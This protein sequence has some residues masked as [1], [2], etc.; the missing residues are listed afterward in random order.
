M[1]DRRG[2]L[3]LF[4]T[5]VHGT[6]CISIRHA[7]YLCIVCHATAGTRDRTN[8]ILSTTILKLNSIFSIIRIRFFPLRTFCFL[9]AREVRGAWIESKNEKIKEQNVALRFKSRAK[10]RLFFTPPKD[11]LSKRNRHLMKSFAQILHTSTAAAMQFSKLR[12]PVP[13]W[14]SAE[15]G[16]TVKIIRKIK[17]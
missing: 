3:A 9:A 16:I 15:R 8:E 1:E 10:H 2:P 4:C 6:H 7:P 13:T 11:L 14:R 12:L 17:M 5:L